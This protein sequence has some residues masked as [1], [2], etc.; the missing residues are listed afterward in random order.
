[1]LHLHELARSLVDEQLDRV[2]I[3]QPVAARDGVV[4]MVVE[5]VV[6]L[7][8][9]GSAAFGGDRVAAHRVDLREQRDPQ[10]RIRLDRRDRSA[11]AGA[12]S[13]DNDDV[14]R[15]Q[16]HW[17]IPAAGLKVHLEASAALK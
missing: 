6:V 13:A 10:R 17:G 8:H 7:D 1:M 12:A 2:L 14:G 11:H 5:A 15:D 3:A 16:V 9:P 4:E